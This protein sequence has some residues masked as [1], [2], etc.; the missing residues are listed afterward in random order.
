MTRSGGLR[1]IFLRFPKSFLLL[2]RG[3]PCPPDK[4]TADVLHLKLGVLEV[5]AFGTFAISV[6]AAIAV[7]YLIAL[8]FRRKG[9]P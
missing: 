5:N 9:R 8:L 4:I 1:F 7:L 3:A 2:L 6:V